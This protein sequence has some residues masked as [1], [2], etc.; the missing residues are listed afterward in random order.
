[1]GMAGRRRVE[2]LF[3]W[4]QIAERTERL[5]ADA[6]ASYRARTEAS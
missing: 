5:Y 6:I 3:S 2:A 4:E 1:M